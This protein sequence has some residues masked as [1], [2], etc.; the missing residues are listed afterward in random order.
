MQVPLLGR[1]LHAIGIPQ[2]PEVQGPQQTGVGGV[3]GA[4]LWLLE[5]NTYRPFLSH[6]PERSLGIDNPV[7]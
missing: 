3:G 2:C 7:R 6:G 4:G 5:E 1:L